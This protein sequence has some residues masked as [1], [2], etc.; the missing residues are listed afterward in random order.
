L[1]I[2]GYATKPLLYMGLNKSIVFYSSRS[3][4]HVR[5][6]L[7]NLIESYTRKARFPIYLVVEFKTPHTRYRYTIVYKDADKIILLSPSNVV[8]LMGTTVG[9]VEKLIAMDLFQHVHSSELKCV[10]TVL[11]LSDDKLS[12]KYECKFNPLII[13]ITLLN[14]IVLALYIGSIHIT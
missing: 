9:S 3:A 4:E 5:F 6:V 1:T 2:E 13:E 10:R 7:T 8:P 12:I 11:P 14:S